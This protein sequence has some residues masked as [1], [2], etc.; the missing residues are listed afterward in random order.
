[1][2]HPDRCS[3]AHCEVDNPY[4]VVEMDILLRGRDGHYFRMRPKYPEN[5]R[6]AMCLGVVE[7]LI[8]TVV[9]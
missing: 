4:H 9:P 7:W 1:M 8:L 6:L 3:L 5:V 2:A